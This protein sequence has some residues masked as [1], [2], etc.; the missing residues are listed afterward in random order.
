MTDEDKQKLAAYLYNT[1]NGD[2]VMI[3]AREAETMGNAKMF[4]REFAEAKVG[5]QLVDEE[6]N[7]G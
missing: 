2:G 6:S 3:P 7:D 5:P 4:L 1:L